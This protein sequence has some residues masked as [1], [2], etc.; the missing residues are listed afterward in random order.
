MWVFIVEHIYIYIYIYILYIYIYIYIH[1]LLVLTN[2]HKKISCTGCLRVDILR[3]SDVLSQTSIRLIYKSSPCQTNIHRK[4]WINGF[5]IIRLSPTANQ[6]LF[7]DN[8]RFQYGIVFDLF[9]HVREGAY[10]SV[11]CGGFLHQVTCIPDF[12]F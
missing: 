3:H 5:W 2:Y 1:W 6:F 12:Y 8:V 7:Y 4:L 11:T 10:N 9:W